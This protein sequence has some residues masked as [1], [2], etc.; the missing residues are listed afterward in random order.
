MTI[1]QLYPSNLANGLFAQFWTS[2]PFSLGSVHLAS[3]EKINDPVITPNL[4]STDFDIAMLAAVGRLSHKAYSTPPL[5]DLIAANTSPGYSTL[6]LDASDE[7]WAAYLKGTGEFA[8]C[9]SHVGSSFA[10]CLI[11]VSNALHTIGT[12]AMLPK[13]LGG[14]VDSQVRVYG[15]RN[16]RVVDAS[17]IP[18]PL[19][20]HAMGP[21]YAV[22][23][24]ASDLIKASW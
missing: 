15:T 3:T 16:V 6:P 20:G 2:L 9:I 19:S 23:E 4:L 14:V 12:C 24:K 17:M 22:A 10:D 18:M 8:S 11:T 7:Q 5:S 21:I 1:A 13:S